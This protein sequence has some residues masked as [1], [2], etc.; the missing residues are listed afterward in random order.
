MI[1]TYALGPPDRQ[2][3]VSISDEVLQPGVAL[4]Q[5]TLRVSAHGLWLEPTDTSISAAV[6][7]EGTVDGG[8][9]SRPLSVIPARVM[10]VRSYP[11]NE[12]LTILLS[13]DQLLLLEA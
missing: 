8:S 9:P 11:I 7:L 3:R 10:N 5:L 1:T 6:L 12:R 13:D 4:H 2:L